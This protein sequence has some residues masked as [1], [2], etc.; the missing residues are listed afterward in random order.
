MAARDVDA[1]LLER[2]VD[3]LIY[4]FCLGEVG[5]ARTD[6]QDILL[7]QDDAGCW[8][9]ADVSGE[10]LCGPDGGAEAA[11]GDYPPEGVWCGHEGNKSYSYDCFHIPVA[12]LRAECLGQEA[13]RPWDDMLTW[14]E[15]TVG[16]LEP[17]ACV[18]DLGCGGGAVSKRLVQR[19]AGVMG[20]DLDPQMVACSAQHCPGGS[21]TCTDVGGLDPSMWPAVL[22]PQAAG[23]WSSFMASYFAQ[24]GQFRA[25]VDAWAQLLRPGGW[26]CMT[27]IDGLFSAHGPLDPRFA[28]VD[29]AVNGYSCSEGLE[30]RC[31]CESCGLVVVAETTWP[32]AEL[33]FQGAADPAQVATW[34]SFLARP[35]IQ[36]IFERVFGEDGAEAA[37]KEFLECLA[38]ER[39]EARGGVRSVVCKKA[40]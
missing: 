36:L 1:L 7:V 9:C 12:H 10:R 31:I 23:V 26:F 25:A 39:H 35:G 5:W 24:E 29:S 11:S 4:V 13:M 27:E 15:T 16:P 19:G 34:T 40:V 20:L 21:F 22:R 28:E 38:S 8:Y 32:D 6:C 37:C 3:S 14:L 2:H 17:G 33:F 18:F 30:F